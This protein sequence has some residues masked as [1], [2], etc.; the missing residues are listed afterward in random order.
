MVS[1]IETYRHGG[2]P[3]YDLSRFN[4]QQRSVIDFSA[5][6]N[7]LGAPPV[8]IEHWPELIQGIKDYPSIEGK[9]IIEY[10]RSKFGLSDGNILAGNGS[11]EIIYLISRYLRLK[12]VVILAPSYHDYERASVLSGAKVIRIPLLNEGSSFGI[13][14][15]RLVE[16]LKISDALWLGRPNNPTADLFP[17][18]M[19]NNLASGFPDK[20]FIID[21][22]F[23]QF[24]DNWEEETFITGHIKPNIMVVHSLTKLYGLGGLRM[25]GLIAHAE[26]I[27]RLKRTKEPW[28]ING[29]ADRAGL[30]LKECQDYESESRAY[31]SHERNKVIKGL[32]RT[33]GVIP[34]SSTTNFILCHWIGTGDLDDLLRHLLVNGTYVRDCRNFPGLED[35]FFRIGLRTSAE[36][37]KLISIISSYKDN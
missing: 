16:A 35:N 7:P 17:K 13:D 21:E 32:Q 23:V 11:T 30:L 9:G 27:S 36:N 28:T 6:L 29:V 8:I 26:I 18:D 24:L 4:L 34:F 22:A 20:W 19:I 25:G 10:Y 31:V 3:S 12:N 37:N 15:Q 5:S 2:N 33:V 1:Q 14:M